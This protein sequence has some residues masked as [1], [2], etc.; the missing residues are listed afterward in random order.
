MGFSAGSSAGQPAGERGSVPLADALG[1][2]PEPERALHSPR[3]EV[4]VEGLRLWTLDDPCRYQ[5]L[6]SL[7]RGDEPMDQAAVYFGM[8]RRGARGNG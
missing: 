6:V 3:I 2:S 1:A 8:R 5:M 4:P 7:M